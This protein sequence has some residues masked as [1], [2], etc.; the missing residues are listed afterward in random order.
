VDETIVE[1]AADLSEVGEDPREEGPRSRGGG[2][3]ET[4]VEGA[5]DLS[6]V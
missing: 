5:A 3:D 6:E 1:G 2:T 4:Y